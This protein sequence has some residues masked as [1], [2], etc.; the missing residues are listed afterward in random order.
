MLDKHP[1]KGSVD[2]SWQGLETGLVRSSMNDS[3]PFKRMSL[4]PLLSVLSVRFAVGVSP[5]LAS[6]GADKRGPKTPFPLVGYAG[7][8]PAICSESR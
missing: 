6:A 4:A 1:T 7:I 3:M 8:Q 5:L 2:A